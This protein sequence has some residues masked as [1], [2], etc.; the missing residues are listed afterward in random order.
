MFTSH[1]ITCLAVIILTACSTLVACDTAE[2]EDEVEVIAYEGS[3]I[4]R[5]QA[6]RPVAWS[7]TYSPESAVVILEQVNPNGTVRHRLALFNAPAPLPEYA[8]YT[9]PNE[10]GNYTL[11]RGSIAIQGWDVDGVVS[12]VVDG[13]LARG[14]FNRAG[15]VRFEFWFD[16]SQE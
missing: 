2:E 6:N 11:A 12:G 7:A 15:R 10:G 8:G 14:A 5:E 13:D 3:T 16:F 4:T 9:Q 1:R